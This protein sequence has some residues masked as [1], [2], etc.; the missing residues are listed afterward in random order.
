MELYKSYYTMINS[1]ELILCCFEIA[2]SKEI[3]SLHFI[4]S[5]HLISV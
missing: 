1:T 2:S 5:L 3:N 4:N